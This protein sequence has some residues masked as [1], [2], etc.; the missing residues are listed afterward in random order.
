MMVR[1]CRLIFLIFKNLSLFSTKGKLSCNA[2]PLVVNYNH[3]QC[4]A[5]CFLR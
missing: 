2:F 4:K 1:D 5:V 3:L